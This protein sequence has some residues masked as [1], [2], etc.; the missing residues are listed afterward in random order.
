MRV[1]VKIFLITMMIFFATLTQA[2]SNVFTEKDSAFIITQRDPQFTIQLKSNPTT[3]Y[4]WFLKSYDHHFIVPTKHVFQANTH[5][6]LIGAPGYELWSF[7][8]KPNAFAVPHQTTIEFSY[9]RPW[10]R[11]QNSTLL[12]FRVSTSKA[13]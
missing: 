8:V 13:R 4:T 2:Q 5:K 3:G 11:E 7:T 6:K 10:E 12:V 1:T 9:A